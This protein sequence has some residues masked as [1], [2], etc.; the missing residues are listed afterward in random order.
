MKTKLLFFLCIF[1]C[2]S[3]YGLEEKCQS[4][5]DCSAPFSID[6][7]P[8]KVFVSFSMPDQ[9]LLDFSHSLEKTRGSL[10]FQGL[11]KNSFAEFSK[12][13]DT[14]EYSKSFTRV[15]IKSY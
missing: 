10:V 14:V 12:T 15:L 2:Y 4:G 1:L 6:E 13:L 5:K 11:P 7:T 3:V 8:L 9:A